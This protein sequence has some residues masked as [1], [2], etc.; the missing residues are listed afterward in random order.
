MF[1]KNIPKN[2]FA[3]NIKDSNYEIWNLIVT[4]IVQNNKLFS[5]IFITISESRSV[6]P[7]E[8][9]LVQKSFSSNKWGENVN[10]FKPIGKLSF[11]SFVDW[12]EICKT[13]SRKVTQLLL[14]VTIELVPFE[15]TFSTH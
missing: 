3:E 5:Q 8:P 11:E 2:N 1:F 9:K 12:I 10:Y 6:L 4:N 15:L 14:K 13:E 7:L